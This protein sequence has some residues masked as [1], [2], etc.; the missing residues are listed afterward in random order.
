[1]HLQQLQHI[2]GATWYTNSGTALVQAMQTENPRA[3]ENF[4]QMEHN[5]EIRIGEQKDNGE[6]ADVWFTKYKLDTEGNHGKLG[7]YSMVNEWV[8]KVMPREQC[9]NTM[10][11]DEKDTSK[12][13]RCR[14]RNLYEV[15]LQVAEVDD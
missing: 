2:T 5:V 4:D 1:M 11:W 9:G 3:Q 6:V 7:I 8:T 12:Q 13:Q 14:R 15:M 10:W